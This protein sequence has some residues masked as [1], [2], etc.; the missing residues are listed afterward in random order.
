MRLGLGV[1]RLGPD[2]FYATTL[3]ELYAAIDGYLEARGIGPVP[4]G[5]P[6]TRDELLQLMRRYPD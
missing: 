6:L 2:A 5:D 1:L 3:P 4:A